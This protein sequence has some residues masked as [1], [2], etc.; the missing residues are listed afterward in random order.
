MIKASME[1]AFDMEAAIPQ[2]L[3]AAIYECY[4]DKGWNISTN[5][6]YKYDNPFADG[7][8]SFDLTQIFHDAH[9]EDGVP[10]SA[11]GVPIDVAGRKVEFS[12]QAKDA[13]LSHQPEL[14]SSPA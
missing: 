7:V 6:N 2:L 12:Y 3:E 4:E 11:S 1:A 8:F 10:V 5:K 13:M 9:M 14:S